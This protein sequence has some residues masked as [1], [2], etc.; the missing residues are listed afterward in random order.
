MLGPRFSGLSK[1]KVGREE[2]FQHSKV[3]VKGCHMWPI[4]GVRMS[5][6]R[7]IQLDVNR[8]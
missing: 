3:S 6:V 7:F 4:G 5:C 1:K 8:L 2:R